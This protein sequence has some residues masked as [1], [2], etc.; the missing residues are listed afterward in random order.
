V[1]KKQLGRTAK[2]TRL[3]GKKSGASEFGNKKWKIKIGKIWTLLLRNP[4]MLE[5]EE[6]DGKVE[7]KGK[8]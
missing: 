1:R 7:Q 3:K 8:K 6:R 2:N 4:C 5:L